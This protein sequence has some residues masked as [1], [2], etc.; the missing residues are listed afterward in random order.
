ME[1]SREINR[2]RDDPVCVTAMKNRL[3]QAGLFGRKT[4]RKPLLTA[5]HKCKR[6]QW[7]KEH[8]NWS[9]EQ[10][11]RHFGLMNRNFN[12]L[13]LICTNMSFVYLEKGYVNL[14]YANCKAWMRK[15]N[16]VDKLWE[17]SGWLFSEGARNPGEESVP[18]CSLVKCYTIWEKVNWPRIYPTTE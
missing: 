13:V 4:V 14:C 2:T 6:L 15:S 9:I 18:S 12:Y 17:Q 11:K 16:G 5:I 3:H 10:W 1:I 8:S 7:A